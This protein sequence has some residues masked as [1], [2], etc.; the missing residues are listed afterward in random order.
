[1]AA[2]R[3]KAVRTLRLE[4]QAGLGPVWTRDGKKV[5]YSRAGYFA[6]LKSNERRPPRAYPEKGAA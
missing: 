2:L 6:W 1:M 5:F 4:R 3:G